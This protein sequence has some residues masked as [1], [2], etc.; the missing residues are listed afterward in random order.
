[1][2]STAKPRRGTTHVGV[3]RRTPL[4]VPV[5]RVDR[6]GRVISGAVNVELGSGLVN[7]E[8]ADPV[9]PDTV[10]KDDPR[11][12]EYQR[13]CQNW[14]C[15]D[16]V[17]Q[18]ED[19]R[20]GDD[21]GS[22]EVCRTPFDFRPKLA[23]GDL[24]ADQYYVKGPM[25]HGGFG[26]IYLAYDRHVNDRP[27]VLKGLLDAAVSDERE[28]IEAERRFLAETEHPA[29]VDIYNFVEHGGRGYIVMKFVGG[30]S[31]QQRDTAHREKAGSP[32]PVE[33]AV[34]FLLA[35]LPALS[36]LHDQHR[37]YCDFKPEN[38]IHVENAVKLI[39]LGAVCRLDA[40]PSA[41][42]G[43]Y[44]YMAPEVPTSGPSVAA[45]LYT[46]GRSLA[47]LILDWPE[48]QDE[49]AER[50][51]RREDHDLLVQ[52]DCLWRFLNRA[53]AFESEDRFATADEMAVALYGVLRQ[54]A[55]SR[56]GEA[57]PYTSTRWTP[58]GSRLDDLTWE[59]LPSPLL[60]NH[61]R[62]ANRVVGLT[63]PSAAVALADLGR[64]LSW[65]DNAAISLAHCGLGNHDAAE[66]AVE[67]LR[68][69]GDDAVGYEPA[70]E[71]ARIYLLG[72][73]SLA[74]GDVGRALT[75]FDTV[76]TMAPG[77][78]ACALAYAAALE[79][80]YAAPPEEDRDLAYLAEAETL[81]YQVAVTDPSWIA[82]VA[83]LAR[84]I[85]AQDRTPGAA[86]ALT[87]V[88]TGHPMHAEALTVACQVMKHGEFDRE[89]DA[90]GERWATARRLATK[91]GELDREIVGAAAEELWD[92]KP[93]TRTGAHAELAVALYRAALVAL[94]EGETLDFGVGD[95]D[96]PVHER[97]LASA[98]EASLLD[99]AAATPDSGRRHELL[100][101]AAR[102]RPWSPW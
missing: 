3:T 95:C 39:D 34:A 63:D 49:D 29:I 18:S 70:L 79:T 6:R 33:Q 19:G 30:P 96:G 54:V 74:R 24:V 100:D 88:P 21:H 86:R 11:V 57:R 53:C 27:C 16:P 80:A 99:L 20:P 58:P 47:V 43:T 68:S 102:T 14:D 36:Y 85:L 90:R 55:A 66:E 25:A 22:C 12:P 87:A 46:V 82:A 93:G 97:D 84:T 64:E 59:V 48:W 83:G 8:P 92:T 31:I 9:D 89:I 61:P 101:S 98:A 40:I 44:G 52:H 78:A 69:T 94:R 10:V 5:G 81:Y 7:I 2:V 1:M 13:F 38:V 76:Y 32:M 35:A 28:L 71:A 77:E 42:A 17:G 37:A 15:G 67:R 41:V 26:W 51:P 65:A 72:L 75:C 23:E 45:D 50:L 73:V 56:D 62:I 4:A 91:H 60:P